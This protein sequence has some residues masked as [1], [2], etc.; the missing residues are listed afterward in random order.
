MNKMK[1]KLPIKLLMWRSLVMWRR[2]ISEVEWRR[3][4]GEQGHRNNWKVKK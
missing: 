1:T 2:A 4:L 3:K